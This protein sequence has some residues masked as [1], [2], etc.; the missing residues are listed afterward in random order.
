MD[1]L[2]AEDSLTSRRLLNR[3]LT[4]MNFNVIETL[5]GEEAWEKLNSPNP[6]RIALID[7]MMPKLDGIGLIKRVRESELDNKM[8]T[9]LIMLT[10][11]SEERDIQTGFIAGADDYIT[12]PIDPQSL[13]VRLRIARR[14]IRQQNNLYE[15]QKE[16]ATQ[17]STQKEQISKAQEIQQ[18]LNTSLIPQID[19]VN[20]QAVYNPCQ[21]MG[22]DFFNIIKTVTN[23]IAVIMVDCTG[24]GLEASMYA[25]LLKSV[26]DRHIHLL[27]KPEYLASFVQMINIDISTYITSDQFPVMFVSIYDPVEM[28]FYYSSANGEHPYLIRDKKVYKLAKAVGMHLGYNTEG[29][30]Q[31]KSFMV[32][33]N[34]IVFFYSDA[35]IEIENAQWNRSDDRILQE[36]LSELG[37]GLRR[38]NEKIMELISSAANSSTLEDDLSLIYFQVKKPYSKYHEINSED[39]IKLVKEEVRA[40]LELFDYWE[41]DI[42]KI[43]ITISELLINAID[44]GNKKDNTKKV[45]VEYKITCKKFYLTIEDEGSGFDEEGIPDPTD[46][47]RLQTLLDNNDEDSYTHGRGVWMVKSFMDNVA[48]SKGGKMVSVSKEKTPTRTLNNYTR[49]S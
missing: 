4:K 3:I 15:I 36:T 17:L 33:D 46:L 45:K 14:I 47:S 38:D 25:T 48:F 42:E 29:Q 16:L 30:Y 27:D 9:Y 19:D 23:K 18:I 28:K 20:I 44:H 43:S 8:Y 11:N 39:Q 13:T 2:I 32:K 1:I 21:E 26:C 35:I 10:S 12:K 31:E 40:K 49:L 34:D 41:N 6:P 22:G 37:M 24:H 7:W 5:D